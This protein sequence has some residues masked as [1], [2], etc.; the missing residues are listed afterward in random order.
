MRSGLAIAALATAIVGGAAVLAA[1]DGQGQDRPGQVGQTRVF[2]ENRGRGDAVPV[3]LQD[4]T[5]PAPIS[6]QLA[7]TPTIAIA[8]QSVVA[9]RL[10]RQAWEYRALRI[11]AGQ[12]PTAL[13]AAAGLDSWEATGIQLPDPGGAML[14]VKRPR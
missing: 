10:V 14:I 9:A 12:Y 13:L 8:P 5:T 11:P 3:V 4:V 6:V 1:P 2:V 7:G